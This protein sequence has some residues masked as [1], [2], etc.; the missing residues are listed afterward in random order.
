MAT[1]REKGARFIDVIRALGIAP[2]VWYPCVN[3]IIVARD[4]IAPDDFA[5]GVFL[6]ARGGSWGRSWDHLRSWWPLHGREEG[7]VVCCN[8]L[9]AH[10]AS[11]AGG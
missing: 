8:E 5:R 6:S 4:A 3:G 2:V 7:L 10:L 1:P 9:R 11:R